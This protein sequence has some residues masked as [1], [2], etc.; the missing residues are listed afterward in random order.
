MKR[1]IM[2][3][4]IATLTLFA[5][6]EPVSAASVLV[7]FSV[8]TDSVIIT[9]NTDPNA[10]LLSGITFSYDNLGNIDEFANIDSSGIVGSTGGRL[11]FDFMPP[12]PKAMGLSFDF[13]LLGVPGSNTPLTNGLVI[14]FN[15]GQTY[16]TNL[17]IATSSFTP[18]DSGNPSGDGDAS[19]SFVYS[20]GPFDQALMRFSSGA[21]FFS[22]ANISY[23]IAPPLMTID[24]VDSI[25]HVVKVTV[26]GTTNT[27]IGIDSSAN[28]ADWSTVST[29]TNF[30]GVVTYDATNL[31]DISMEFFRSYYKF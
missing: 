3:M 26:T 24:R 16:V 2:M 30:T 22:V 4:A 28:L 9:T 17:T 10:Y 21:G 8:L 7:N 31:P 6:T 18:Y 1:N 20:G 23:E 27:V 12:T 14:T 19:G 15:D 29:M 11:Y 25:A 13:S 5:A